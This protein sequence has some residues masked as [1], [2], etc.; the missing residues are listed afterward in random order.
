[1]SLSAKALLLT[2][3]LATGLVYGRQDVRVGAYHFPPY[4]VKPE[5]A[6]PTGVLPDL[7]LAFN[8]A[9]DAYRFR[10]VA[11]SSMRRYQD[12]HS[13]RF[14][15]MLFESPEWGWQG[16][17]HRSLDL[18]I[19]DAEVYVARRQSGRDEHYFDDFK[20]KRMALYSGYHYGF[21][22]FSADR[23]FL[24]D[25]FN[26]VLTYSHDSNLAMLLRGRADIAV[27]TRSYLRSFQQRNVE[28]GQALLVSQ[29]VDQIYRH[30]ALFALHSAISPQNFAVLLEQLRRNQRLGD[31]LRRHH[32]Q[33]SEVSVND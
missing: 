13:G 25:Q 11:T 32:V 30:Q 9:Q 1:M 2:L 14:D 16:G 31:V 27:V 12:L 15:L 33:A 3:L 17:A 22:G 26:A 7:L 8:E 19:E 29:R 23:Q 21:A 4:V 5:S 20:G 10:L 6:Q 28:Q 18:K 24:T